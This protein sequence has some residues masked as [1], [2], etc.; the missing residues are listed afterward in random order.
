MHSMQG[1]LNFSM[2]FLISDEKILQTA[3]CM[4]NYHLGFFISN[5]G[6]LT[7]SRKNPQQTF[8]PFAG[9]FE[10]IKAVDYPYRFTKT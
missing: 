3:N 7:L 2:V 10:G 5:K 6:S 4:I 1:M 8:F 9:V